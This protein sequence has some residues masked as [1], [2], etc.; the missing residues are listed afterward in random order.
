[1][2]NVLKIER[3]MKTN[4]RA[5]K[6]ITFG[7]TCIACI[8]CCFFVFRVVQTMRQV[9]II[10]FFLFL[11]RHLSTLFLSYYPLFFFY[12]WLVEVL[13]VFFSIP[14]QTLCT[15][16]FLKIVFRLLSLS[17]PS[18]SL[19]VLHFRYM[20]GCCLFLFFTDHVCCLYQWWWLL[21]VFRCGAVTLNRNLI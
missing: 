19:F 4:Q 11:L 13:S 14:I 17:P 1:M 21:A 5:R 8:F 15:E 6:M 16:A 2:P 20:L 10:S 9:T 18:T 12:T 3:E 7:C